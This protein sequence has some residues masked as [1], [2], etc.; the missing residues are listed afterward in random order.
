MKQF[1]KLMDVKKG[2]KNLQIKIKLRSLVSLV[3]NNVINVIRSCSAVDKYL[4]FQSKPLCFK[5]QLSI[6]NPSKGEG[7]FFP[8]ADKL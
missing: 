5:S 8:I 6:M 3:F 1:H 4:S 2:I 7:D